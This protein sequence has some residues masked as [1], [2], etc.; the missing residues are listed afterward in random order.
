MSVP[1]SVVGRVIGL[2][3]REWG[4]N[5]EWDHLKFVGQIR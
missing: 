2:L 5:V 4:A 1:S 3:R